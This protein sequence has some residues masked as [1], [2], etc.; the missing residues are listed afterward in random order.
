MQLRNASDAPAA[1]ARRAAERPRHR[2]ALIV[3][4]R[5]LVSDGEE[6]E[7]LAVTGET[8]SGYGGSLNIGIA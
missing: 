7:L 3:R 1:R 4:R 5:R 8:T 6:E 2:I